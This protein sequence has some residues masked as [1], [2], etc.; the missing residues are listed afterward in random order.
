M[1]VVC[2]YARRCRVAAVASPPPRRCPRRRRR[3][4]R[5]RRQRQRRP[6]RLGGDGA[7]R[8]RCLRS[9]RDAWEATV[10]SPV[11]HFSSCSSRLAPDGVTGQATLAGMRLDA[12]WLRQFAQE[13]KLCTSLCPH[14]SGVNSTH[15]MMSMV[16]KLLGRVLMF[17][18]LS[19][20]EDLRTL[21]PVEIGIFST[22]LHTH[23][24][25]INSS[26]VKILKRS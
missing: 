15:A 4:S 22:Y 24:P 12:P 11:F 17:F 23:M 5:R 1:I 7:S 3:R 8:G 21:P 25:K 26:P 19:L 20:K 2:V 13:A 9:Y 16:G 10:S 14:I 18:S 6:R